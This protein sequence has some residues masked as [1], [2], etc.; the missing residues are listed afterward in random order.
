MEFYI[1]YEGPVPSQNTSDKENKK[2]ET[3]RIRRHFHPQLARLWDS[4]FGPLANLPPRSEQSWY[5]Q[6]R[7]YLDEISEKATPKDVREGTKFRFLPIVSKLENLVCSLDITLYR[8]KEPGSIVGPSG[9]LDNR[10]K[11][12]FDAMS[13]PQHA[14]QLTNLTPEQG[15]NPLYCLMEDDSLIT[16]YK[17]STLQLW[18]TPESPAEYENNYFKVSIKV[19]MARTK[20]AGWGIAALPDV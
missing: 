16:E 19:K 18:T 2:V 14:N 6:K 5:E 10:I 8:R 9:D 11:V 17:I 1:Q 12:L 3:H 13:I 15:E 7:K 20:F 4:R